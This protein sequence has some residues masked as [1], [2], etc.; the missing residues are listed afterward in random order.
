VLYAELARHDLDVLLPADISA[1]VRHV[2]CGDVRCTGSA[3]ICQAG[4]GSPCC[5][6][7]TEDSRFTLILCTKVLKAR[8]ALLML[9]ISR[10]HHCMSPCSAVFCMVVRALL[11]GVCG[12]M[13]C[14]QRCKNRRVLCV[15]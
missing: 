15:H 4:H 2:H 3:I 10:H 6:R 8:V 5:A 12:I 14:C 7:S 1:E 13:V 11:I 9:L